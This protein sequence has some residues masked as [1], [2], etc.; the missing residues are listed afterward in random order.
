[1][2]LL[3][4]ALKNPVGRQR[5]GKLLSRGINSVQLLQ[6]YG[7]AIC[8]TSDRRLNVHQT[9]TSGDL[10]HVFCGVMTFQFTSVICQ[11]HGEHTELT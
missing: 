6:V 8:P 3:G 5:R 1:M 10:L 4:V 7:L 9:H 11:Q 2:A